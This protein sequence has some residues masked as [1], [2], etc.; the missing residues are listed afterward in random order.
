MVSVVIPTRSRSE[1]LRQLLHSILR[2]KKLPKEIIV[3][4]DSDNHKTRELTRQLQSCFLK[5]GVKLKYLK[6]LDTK[7][8]S[9]SRARNIGVAEAS[10]DIVLF[11]DDD[12]V[13]YEDYVEKILNFFKGHP[14]ALGVQGCIT[15]LRMNNFLNCIQKIFY[16]GHVENGR[17]RILPSGEP[18]FSL[19]STEVIQCEWLSGTNCAYRKKV[20]MTFKFNEKLL[21]YSFGEDKEMSYNIQKKYP[22]TLYM[23]PRARA[24]HKKS[25]VVRRERKHLIY[26]KTA[27]PAYFFYNDIEQTLLNKIIFVWSMF[28][29]LLT[30]FFR[31]RNRLAPRE[32][33]FLIHSYIWT[34]KHINEVK[35]GAFSFF[36]IC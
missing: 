30:T 29:R 5:K 25:P 21:E 33:W 22:Q 9:I 28:G 36:D 1:N 31:K 24:H 14:T 6:P 32:L 16:L 35:K 13:I 8:K 26:I 10:C 23:T 20:F 15:G 2:Q 18:T 27:Y 3:V 4:D 17:W 7:K 19:G 12:V 34:I 11:L